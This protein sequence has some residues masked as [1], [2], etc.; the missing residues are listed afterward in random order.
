M[1]KLGFTP[2]EKRNLSI[3]YSNFTNNLQAASI[4][5]TSEMHS[6]N[7]PPSE[8]CQI[9][10]SGSLSRATPYLF[11]PDSAVDVKKVMLAVN[12]HRWGCR[13]YGYFE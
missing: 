8:F 6:G 7:P 11:L 3:F 2:F 12:H 4:F 1:N 9:R 10:E 13:W 5:L